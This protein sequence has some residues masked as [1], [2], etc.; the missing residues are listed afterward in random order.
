MKCTPHQ[1]MAITGHTTMKEI[2]RYTR[3]FLKRE[4]AQQVNEMF[5]K[6][7]LEQYHDAA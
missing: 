7:W 6:E 5:L 4:A 2:E 1:I 3:K